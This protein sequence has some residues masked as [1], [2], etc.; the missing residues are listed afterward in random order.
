MSGQISFLD[1]MIHQK[2]RTSAKTAVSALSICQQC[3]L[4]PFS[5]RSFNW[6]KLKNRIPNVG[7]ESAIK[8]ALTHNE[9]SKQALLSPSFPLPIPFTAM[10]TAFVAALASLVALP[11]SAVPA[12]TCTLSQTESGAHTVAAILTNTGTETVKL[13]NDPRTVLS[14]AE[15]ETFTITGANG[16]PD[17]TGIRMKYSPEAVV[18]ENNP[19]SFTV[20]APGESYEVVHDLSQS[21]DFSKAGEYQIKALDALSYVDAS[22]KLVSLKATTEPFVL[23]LGESITPKRD[24]RPR[25]SSSRIRQTVG[26]P[27]IGCSDSQKQDIEKAI[28]LAEGYATEAVLYLERLSTGSNRYTSWFG[29]FDSGRSSLVKSHFKSIQGKS[30]STTYDCSTCNKAGVFAYVY[31]NQ[32]GKIYLCPQFWRANLQGT[33]SKAGTLVHEQSHFD[34]SGGTRDY[35][36]GQHGC[37]S[38]AKSNPDMAVMNADNHE[39][40]A[41][42]TP[43]EN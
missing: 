12:I 24:F 17:F 23:K 4:Y 32:P 31:P 11:A 27:F 34:A 35:A 22:G 1:P 29:G 16:S 36:Y 43:S 38:L 9:N 25:G 13:L 21:F 20:L 40:F 18:K 3:S 5:R 37:R 15:T 30:S 6:T 14:D 41:E 19:S 8:G 10:R 2:E 7:V 33:D 39:Y 42:N 26:P 28:P